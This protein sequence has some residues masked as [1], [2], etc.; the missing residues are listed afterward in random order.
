MEQRVY[1][2]GHFPFGLGSFGVGPIVEEEE[3]SMMVKYNA[4]AKFTVSLTTYGD[5]VFASDLAFEVG[6][7]KISKDGGSFQN[8]T[9]LPVVSGTIAVV[10]LT[11]AETTAKFI[12]I[13]FKD[14]SVQPLW[15]DKYITMET[16]GDSSAFF[17]DKFNGVTSASNLV[18][19]KLDTASL[20]T[21][22]QIV[23]VKT[24][25]L[26]IPTN[27]SGIVV[28][29]S[30]VDLG[31]TTI[32]LG[33][34]SSGIATV[35]GT[36]Q[37]LSADVKHI[38][39]NNSGIVVSASNM[40]TPTEVVAYIDAHSTKLDVAVSTRASGA[41]LAV[42]KG[43]VDAS[44]QDISGIKLITDKFGFDA[45][46]HVMV[47]VA[48]KGVLNN[49]TVAD[50]FG[51]NIDGVTAHDALVKLLALATGNIS[52][53][54]QTFKYLKQDNSTVAFE[55]SASDVARTRI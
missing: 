39:I 18:D 17:G 55:F 19:I 4:V 41:D 54:G 30:N 45:N 1:R 49:I 13:Q 50:I 53:V 3:N 32:T 44:K 38:P 40:I 25:V 20:A 2:Y 28:S 42:V 23:D 33:N 24:S 36:I 16:F 11:A 46:G 52:V 29:A 48:D 37:S 22:A 26:A 14:Q 21:S 51:V 7:I 6:D 9:T 31:P 12:Q 47:T 35:M 5:V 27:N 43:V 10:N 15:T 34:L 8:I